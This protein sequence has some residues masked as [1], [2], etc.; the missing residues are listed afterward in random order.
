MKRPQNLLLVEVWAFCMGSQG[1]PEYHRGTF[2]SIC[3]PGTIMVPK[4]FYTHGGDHTPSDND[5]PTGNSCDCLDAGSQHVAD[6]ILCGDFHL[7][8]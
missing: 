7:I 3:L 8:S 1:H 2:N 5:I 6:G 4:N